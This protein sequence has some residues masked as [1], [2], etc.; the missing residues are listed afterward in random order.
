MASPL[1]ILPWT[2]R[3][4][5]ELPS[6]GYDAVLATLGYERRSREVPLQLREAS[7]RLAP[8]FVGQH[9]GSYDSNRDQLLAAQYDVK[10]VDEGAFPQLVRTFLRNADEAAEG[11]T[12]RVAID[13]SSMSRWRIAAV[14]EELTQPEP[15]G[16]LI[17]DLLYAPA[18][19]QDPARTDT[20]I[21]NVEPVSP[22]LAGW[23]DDLDQPLAAIIGVG[24]ELEHASSAIDRL[25]PEETYVFVPQGDDPRYLAEVERSN[26]GLLQQSR[27]IQQSL[28]YT[29]TDPYQ[30][31]QA[32]ETLVRR[33]RANERIALV[34]LGP[35][36]F[37]ACASLVCSLHHPA[38]Q[39]IR[40]SANERRDPIDSQADGTICGLR[41][42]VGAVD[43][44]TMYEAD[45]T[46]PSR[47]EVQVGSH[48]TPA[49]A[50]FHAS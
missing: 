18:S 28:T 2:S 30:T 37:A 14:V 36:I 20:P 42:A 10:A 50:R 48:E 3:Q 7:V 19:F 40:V 27:D 49:P 46:V 45:L 4:L 22:Y 34:P 16:D 38:A 25:E 17:V 39:L 12:P 5:N 43:D 11:P 31:F 23:W 41:L 6:D 44:E 32:I 24:Y 47:P 33:L 8:A 13:I 29:V 1:H 15:L 21:L 35:K 26:Q 9:V